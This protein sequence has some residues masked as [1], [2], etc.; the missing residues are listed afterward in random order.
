MSL[1][2]T[3]PVFVGPHSV[4][5]GGGRP[6]GTSEPSRQLRAP[7]RCSGRPPTGLALGHG[8]SPTLLMPW[9]TQSATHSCVPGCQ[10]AAIL[11]IL[12]EML[13]E[14]SPGLGQCFLELS[15]VPDTPWAVL[16]VSLVSGSLLPAQPK[17]FW[18]FLSADPDPSCQTL[19]A[20]LSLDPEERPCLTPVYE[21]LAS[22]PATLSFA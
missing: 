3:H 21:N 13:P 7:T 20:E 5:T 2:H 22:G 17:W 11:Y 18:G 12:L 16:V 1:P 4:C 19:P 14:I 15:P 6:S 10:P 9:V 8:P